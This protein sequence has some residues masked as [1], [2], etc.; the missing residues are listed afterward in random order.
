MLCAANIKTAFM[1]LPRAKGPDPCPGGSD[2][3]TPEGGAGE[4]WGFGEVV[5]AWRSRQSRQEK[6][7]KIRNDG[8]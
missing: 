5:Q 2:C 6:G 4:S 7:C 3:A 8:R 1:R